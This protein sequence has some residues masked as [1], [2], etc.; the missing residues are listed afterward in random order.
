MMSKRIP[1]SPGDVMEDQIDGFLAVLAVLAAVGF[2]LGW[3]TRMRS[4]VRTASLTVIGGALS[5]PMGLLP[6]DLGPHIGILLVLMSYTVAAPPFLL[7]VALGAR[8]RR[9][10]GPAI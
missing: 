8:M 3:M 1:A 2:G 9:P 5:A 10:Y 4:P 7:S 6:V